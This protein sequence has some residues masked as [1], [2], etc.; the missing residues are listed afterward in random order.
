MRLKPVLCGAPAYLQRLMRFLARA[1][2]VVLGGSLFAFALRGN[3]H[4]ALV[5]SDLF[6]C[7]KAWCKGEVRGADLERKKANFSCVFAG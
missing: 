3:K 6:D 4:A 5:T 7:T 2:Q 1:K